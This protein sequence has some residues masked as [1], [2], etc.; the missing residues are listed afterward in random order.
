ML[1]AK[2][3]C[4]F[5]LSLLG[6]GL[7]FLLLSPFRS[8]RMKKYRLEIFS[9]WSR[10]ILKVFAIHV[11]QN[12]F[13]K[14]EHHGPRV[15]VANHVS[16][17][18]IPVLASLGPTL[19]LAKHEVSQ[20]PLMGWLGRCLGMIYVDRSSLKSR[21]QA[22]SDIQKEI[23]AGVS[24]VIF[25]EGTTS[26]SGPLRGR[27]P[28]FAGA[29]RVARSEKVPVE[30]FYLEYQPLDQ[31]A[32][33]GDASFGAHLWSFLNL[34]RVRVKLRREWISSV[35][36]REA[37]RQAYFWSRQWILEGGHGFFSGMKKLLWTMAAVISL[38]IV[39]S[40]PVRAQPIGEMRVS[41]SLTERLAA[42]V[43]ISRIY[44]CEL[45]RAWLIK[46]RTI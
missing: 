9:K 33:L 35:E 23:R 29:F 45:R 24:V 8:D 13:D 1:R 17:L 42:L 3:L 46:Y 2:K 22:I 19:F 15:I 18:D 5:L 10:W 41:R 11:S 6:L 14:S 16:Y 32:W 30:I 39:S 12:S 25:P 36:H 21:A 31:C 28:F 44:R 38:S 7:I 40:A 37:Q 26:E 43:Q 20:W 4:I 34:R 27:V